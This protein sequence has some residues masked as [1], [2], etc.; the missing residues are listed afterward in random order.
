MQ[1]VGGRGLAVGPRNA[2]DLHAPRRISID[3]PGQHRQSTPGICYDRGRDT[4]N[5]ALSHDEDGPTTYGLG[6]ELR[7][8]TLEARDRDEGEARLYATGI[9]RHSPHASHAGRD[10][11]PE[12]SGKLCPVQDHGSSLTRANTRAPR[13]FSQK[14]TAQ[15]NM[16]EIPLKQQ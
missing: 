14:D 3:L 16:P 15:R 12:N 13:R 4:R 2:V 1:D 10:L 11:R 8:V 7:S 6:R 5:V 9:V